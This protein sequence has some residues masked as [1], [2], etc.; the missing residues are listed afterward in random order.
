M[1]ELKIAEVKQRIRNEVTLKTDI[2]FWE[3]KTRIEKKED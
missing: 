1:K 3:R 2:Y